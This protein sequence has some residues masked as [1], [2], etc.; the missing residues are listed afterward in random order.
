MMAMPMPINAH[1]TMGASGSD[2][3]VAQVARHEQD[4]NNDVNYGKAADKCTQS[5]Q[6]VMKNRQQ[7]QVL[8]VLVH[9]VF[10][11][12]PYMGQYDRAFVP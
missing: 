9:R 8:Q 2:G 1:P 7:F 5:A 3:C 4:S 6:N 12:T 11:V 10:L